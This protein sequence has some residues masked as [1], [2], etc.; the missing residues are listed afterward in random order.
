VS[1]RGFIILAFLASGLAASPV[2]AQE[3]GDGSM[4]VV[5]QYVHTDVFSDDVA[6]YDYWTTDTHALVLSGDYTFRD[7]WTVHVALPYV[8]KRFVS[9]VEWG[10]DPHNPNDPWWIDFVPPDKR[11]ID[12]GDYHGGFQD[13]SVSVS[14]TAV[15]GPLTISPYIGYGFPVDDYPFYAKA[16]IGF[17]LWTIPVGTNF[18]Y[19]PYF[20]DWYVSGN[21]AY[22]FSE[23][24]LGVN[25]DYWTAHLS[26]GY[27]FKPEF[28]AHVF[29][30]LKHV[31]DGLQMPWDFTDD[32]TYGNYPDAF[33]TEEW[34]NHDRLL[35]HR[36][37]NVGVG[38]DYFLNRK[39]KISGSFYTGVRAEQSSEPA[40]ALSLGITRFFGND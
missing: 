15:E 34:Y 18:T 31:I 38:F 16:A 33:D 27:W 9:E 10:G 1:Q 13:L 37:L 2:Y 17:N 14:Y 5:Y 11:F 25:V 26:T 39:Y 29:V 3:K 12:D 19:V 20:S 40:E 21:V 23:K 36:N 24:P 8:Q 6:D 32:P 4:S 22:V 35:Q 7:N 28:S 30:A